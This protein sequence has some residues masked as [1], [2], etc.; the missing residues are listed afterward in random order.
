M[1]DGISTGFDSGPRSHVIPNSEIRPAPVNPLTQPLPEGTIRAGNSN[2]HATHDID[3]L[4]SDNSAL[5][6]TKVSPFVNTDLISE[7]PSPFTMWLRS[8]L[9]D[10]KLT[11][12]EIAR[13]TLIDHSAISKLF[14]GKHQPNIHTAALLFEASRR[15]D[16][17]IYKVIFSTVPESLQASY[18]RRKR[19]LR[20]KDTAVLTGTPVE[21]IKSYIERLGLEEDALV[22]RRA[23]VGKST[24]AKIRRGLMMPTFNVFARLALALDLTPQQA[25]GYL[26]AVVYGKTEPEGEDKP[27]VAIGVGELRESHP[28]VSK[29]ITSAEESSELL[30]VKSEKITPEL[31]GNIFRIHEGVIGGYPRGEQDLEDPVVLQTNY[32]DFITQL[33]QGEGYVEWGM[34][35]FRSLNN[36]KGQFVRFKANNLLADYYSSEAQSIAGKYLDSIGIDRESDKGR[37]VGKKHLRELGS[38][39]Q[40][41]IDEYLLSNSLTTDNVHAIGRYTVEVG[42]AHELSTGFYSLSYRE[43]QAKSRERR[44]AA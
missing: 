32:Q 41:T 17:N 29:E 38:K 3:S 35:D 8:L 10:K 33:F 16:N 25:R 21:Q 36:E 27:K 28:S 34:L 7:N 23:G 26:K 12:I 40:A 4:P 11:Q 6:S 20:S 19:F 44:R 43:R 31:L 1:A 5:D 14:A 9:S 24:I 42:T 2:S 39:L 13:I 15:S 37:R 22:G 18:L 30:W